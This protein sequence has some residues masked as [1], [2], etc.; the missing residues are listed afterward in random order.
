M[1]KIIAPNRNEPLVS[2]AGQPGLRFSDVLEALVD[3]VNALVARPMNTQDE[4]YTFLITDDQTVVRKTS[5]TASQAYTIPSNDNVSFDIGTVL[6]VQNDGTADLD[7]AIED[8]TL[9]FEA[10]GTTGTRTIAASGSGRFVK[11]EDTDWKCRG[12]QMT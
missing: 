9:T 6:E 3:G 4:D 12:Q 8:D 11:V 7:V 5:T 10:D 1:T 2:S